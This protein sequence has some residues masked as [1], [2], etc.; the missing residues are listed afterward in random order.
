MATVAASATAMPGA[1][2]ARRGIRRRLLRR[3]GAP[4]PGSASSRAS[5]RASTSVGSA[6]AGPARAARRGPTRSR[7]AL[8]L[9]YSVLG[10]LVIAWTP[11]TCSW[12]PVVS[13]S[14]LRQSWGASR[15]Q[16]HGRPRR[17]RGRAA[18]WPFPRGSPGSRRPPQV[19]VRGCR[20]AR[21]RRGS[22]APSAASASSIASLRSRC[23]PASTGAAGSESSSS[24]AVARRRPI[25]S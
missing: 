22:R 21:R 20:R 11:V 17:A 12:F 15:A 9:A 6:S 18:T 1:A 8:D 7:R 25:R 10:H 19:S 14:R 2:K 5:R 23:S 3:G 13:H 16:G 24:V 4:S